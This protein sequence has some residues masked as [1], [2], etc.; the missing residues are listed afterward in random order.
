M[1]ESL[2]W[3]MINFKARVVEGVDS[4]TKLVHISTATPVEDKYDETKWSFVLLVSSNQ[5]RGLSI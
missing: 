2:L 4:T 1:H 3:W 5:N